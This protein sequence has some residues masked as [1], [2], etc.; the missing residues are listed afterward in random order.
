MPAHCL[1]IVDIDALLRWWQC[2][3]RYIIFC[4]KYNPVGFSCFFFAGTHWFP[5]D[6]GSRT[7]FRHLATKA[8]HNSMLETKSV[9]KSVKFTDLKKQMQMKAGGAHRRPGRLYSCILAKKKSLR[10]CVEKRSQEPAICT[11]WKSMVLKKM[12]V[13]HHRLSIVIFHWGMRYAP[14]SEQLHKSPKISCPLR[15]VMSRLCKVWPLRPPQLQTKPRDLGEQTIAARMMVQL[16]NCFV[17][18][19]NKCQQQIHQWGL[20]GFA[21]G[22][23]WFVAI[24][25]AAWGERIGVSRARMCMSFVSKDVQGFTA[26][27]GRSFAGNLLVETCWNGMD[28]MDSMDSTISPAYTKRYGSRR[29]KEKP[30]L[31]QAIWPGQIW[32]ARR[33]EHRASLSSLSSHAGGGR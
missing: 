13:N 30:C 14:V 23:S 29:E 7:I 28:T 33:Q 8:S 22:H 4:W 32:T 24:A 9:L 25:F 26:E 5:P 2:I 12:M 19:V 17:T 18:L 10:K 21:C 11:L 1:V 20:A 16:R 3:L 31:H 6:S 27:D 15:G